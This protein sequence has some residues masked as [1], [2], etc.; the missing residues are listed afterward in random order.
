MECGQC[1]A[2]EFALKTASARYAN[3]LRV[4]SPK[5]GQELVSARN[6]YKLA[7]DALRIHREGHSKP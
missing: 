3:L 4:K 7:K 2:F 5:K 6:A 1:D